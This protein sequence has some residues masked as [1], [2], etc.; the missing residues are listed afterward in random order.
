MLANPAV[1]LRFF[2]FGAV[3]LVGEEGV[4]GRARSGSPIV[5]KL[6]VDPFKVDVEGFG[7]GSGGIGRADGGWP[8]ATMV[9]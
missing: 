9:S 7:Y 2:S 5:V 8:S 4:G 3:A 6:M 1:I